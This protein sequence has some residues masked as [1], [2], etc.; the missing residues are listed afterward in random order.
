MN[1][2]DLVT[3]LD[4]EYRSILK[5]CDIMELMLYAIEEIRM[6]NDNMCAVVDN[7]I[8]YLTVRQL[9]GL[10]S[11][12]NDLFEEACVAYEFLIGGKI[13]VR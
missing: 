1:D 13:D 12:T 9:T 4:K 2:Y 10:T 7:C 3:P 11:R 5:F 6:G 8:Q